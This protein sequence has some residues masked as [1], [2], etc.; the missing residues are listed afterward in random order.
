MNWY[1]NLKMKAKLMLGFAATIVLT[2]FIGYE[3]FICITRMQA[4]TEIL[5]SDGVEAQGAAIQLVDD[6]ASMRIAVRD[7]LLYNDEQ[8]KKQIAMETFNTHRDSAQNILNMIMSVAA[9]FPEKEASVKKTIDLLNA[10]V[11]QAGIVIDHA[12]AN[13]V[14]EGERAMTTTGAVANKAFNTALEGMTGLMQT[15][16][17][18]EMAI[19]RSIARTSRINMVL[20][21]FAAMVLAFIVGMYISNMIVVRMR[22]LSLKINQISAGD[23]TVDVRATATDEIGDM[24]NHLGAMVES[25]RQVIGGVSQGVDSVASGSTELSAS[26][27][28]M[29]HT[30]SQISLSADKQRSGAE[31]MA[32]AMAELSASIDEVS[33][34][35]QNSITQLESALEATQQGNMA[36]ESTKGAMDDIT[37]TTGRIA[38][39]IGV[40]QEI[41]NQTNLLSLN[42]AIEAA[43]AGEQGKGFAVVAEEVRKLAERSATSAKE[44]AQHNIEA[45]NSVERGGEMVATTVELLHKIKA[46]LDQ[47]AVQTRA[48][49]TATL[50][51]AKAGEDV[52]HQVE[53]SVGE[54]S[55]VASATSQIGA[56]TSEVAR[57]AHE[58]ASL[59]SGLQSQIRRFKMV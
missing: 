38:Q 26:A 55:N 43:K 19:S 1:R 15:V 47:F 17:K 53:A 13:R 12:M 58:L 22:N 41:A 4:T 42:A 32:A 50:E 36:G 25:L 39:A 20:F 18:E 7:M 6:F 9:G 51:Q 27:E 5:Y 10:Y 24:G 37:Q 48:S 44:I 29:S 31:R 2:L 28:E 14:V 30:T 34:G 11:E 52:A 33:R 56:T 23:L 49:V 8:E 3:G 40:I 54:A 57:T 59:A 46:S 21:T 35:G 45:R 16:S